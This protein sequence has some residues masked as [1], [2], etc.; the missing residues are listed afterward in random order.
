MIAPELPLTLLAGEQRATSVFVVAPRESLY[1]KQAVTFRV[2]D[3]TGVIQ[4]LPY[5]LLGPQKDEHAND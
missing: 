4:D 3:D 1:G 2:I 5:T